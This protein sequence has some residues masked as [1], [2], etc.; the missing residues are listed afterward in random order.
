MTMRR[1]LL[2]G[3]IV[4]CQAI[5]SA[6]SE[7]TMTGTVPSTSTASTETPVTIIG[8]GHLITILSTGFSPEMITIKVGDMVTWL[9][10]DKINRSIV[11][12]YH[13]QDEDNIS[14]MFFGETWV[15][16]DI[17]P[18][19]T[20]SYIFNQSGTFE[21]MALPLQVRLPMDQYVNVAQAGVGFV[22]V[23]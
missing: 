2:I 8:E 16:S 7:G 18:G 5:F 13:F 22:L 20:Y 19:H 11:S 6:C 3:I 1:I 4:I 14:H 17:E 12:L 10:E 9:N 21:Y 15:G 23:E